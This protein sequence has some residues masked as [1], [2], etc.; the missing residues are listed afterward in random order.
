MLASPMLSRLGPGGLAVEY[1]KMTTWYCS[2]PEN[3]ANSACATTSQKKVSWKTAA[4][5]GKAYCKEAAAKKT[6]FFCA[7]INTGQHMKMP[8]QHGMGGSHEQLAG[9]LAN[10]MRNA[11]DAKPFMRPQVAGSASSA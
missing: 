7:M 1:A 10:S 5:M 9:A 11:K 4:E 3:K 6:S 2:K 8:F